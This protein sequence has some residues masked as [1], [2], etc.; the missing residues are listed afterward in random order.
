MLKNLYIGSPANVNF[1]SFTNSKI[2]L[3]SWGPNFFVFFFPLP[4][5]AGVFLEIC[6][7][8]PLGVSFKK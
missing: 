5:Y 7:E 4:N 3:R 2:S 1:W 6:K 8:M